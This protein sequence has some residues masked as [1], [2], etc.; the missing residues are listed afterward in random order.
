MDWIK[1]FQRS[2]DYI[3]EHLAEELPIEEI[4]RPMNISAFYYQRIFTMICGFSV[5]EYI[6]GRRLT[7]AGSEL[8][9]TNDKIIDI[10]LKYGYDTPEGFTRAFSKFHGS[11]PSAV[12]KGAPIRSFARLSVTISM[13]G[14][15][16]MDYR[17]ERSEAFK[18]LEK[19]EVHSISENQNNNTIPEFWERAHKNGTVEKLLAAASDK[20]D[21]FG[22]CYA[23][24][25]K[26]E[27]T[28]DYSIAVKYDGSS[29]VPEGFTVNEIP[30]RTWAVFPCTGAMP[31][32]IQEL[33]HR[34]CTEFFPSSSYEPTYEMDI[35]V[36]TDGDMT[37]DN[38]RSEIRVPVKTDK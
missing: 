31:K 7:N 19:R 9:S 1:S 4:A 23:N 24:P 20:T 2:I 5:G 14:G 6:R 17:I 26:D 28:F 32:A 37:S 22:I 34:I 38:Y 12:R 11:S 21:I 8:A 3:E 13:K 16:I 36:Y 27:S 18:V 30:A 33:W 35:E 29:P 25:H 15:K 10:A